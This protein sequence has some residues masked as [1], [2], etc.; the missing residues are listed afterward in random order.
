MGA[1]AP[2]CSE[3]AE[4]VGEETLMGCSLG[5]AAFLNPGTVHIW[6]QFSM[7]GDVLCTVGCLAAS[8]ASTH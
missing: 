1:G 4:N 7:V 6:G 3:S 2:Q 5:G 8:L